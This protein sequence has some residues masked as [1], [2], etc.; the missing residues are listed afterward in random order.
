MKKETGVHNFDGS[1]NPEKSAEI[2][3]QF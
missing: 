1:R 2:I 3:D